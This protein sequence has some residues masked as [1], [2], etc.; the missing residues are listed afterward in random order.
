MRS[1]SLFAAGLALVSLPA[2]AQAQSRQSLYIEAKPRSWLDAG[3]VYEPG[4]SHGYVYDNRLRACRAVA[5]PS[6]IQ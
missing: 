3:K 2:M 5:L 6:P 4:A 1:L